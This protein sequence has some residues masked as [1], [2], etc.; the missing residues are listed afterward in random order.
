MEVKKF[1][2]SLFYLSFQH[3]WTHLKRKASFNATLVSLSQASTV[4]QK[5]SALEY[6]PHILTVSKHSMPLLCSPLPQQD[7]AMQMRHCDGNLVPKIQRVHKH[8]NIRA[9]EEGSNVS[10][11]MISAVTRPLFVHI[12][13]TSLRVG[14]K[15]KSCNR[16]PDT[17]EIVI[18][19]MC[20]CRVIFGGC[21]CMVLFF[22]STFNIE[23]SIG[24]TYQQ[25]L[26]RYH[27]SSMLH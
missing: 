20:M 10:S 24:N 26:T 6:L 5:L 7:L 25:I 22:Q 21:T 11:S 9:L 8:S 19:I 17:L 2:I 16:S 18:L 23:A 13:R 12:N 1:Y 15:Q 27:P 3:T 14:V 4:S